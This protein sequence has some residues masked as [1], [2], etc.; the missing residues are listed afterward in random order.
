MRW[1]GQFYYF[2][3]GCLI[4]SAPFV[5][6]MMFSPMY[7][8]GIFVINQLTI[9]VCIFLELLVLFHWCICLS[10][11]PDLKDYLK[12]L[13]GWFWRV[14]KFEKTLENMYFI[15]STTMWLWGQYWET[16]TAPLRLQWTYRSLE[17]LLKCKFWYSKSELGP[18]I[19]HF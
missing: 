11:V 6:N 5:E 9:D 17:L 14:S 3:C 7:C 8:P 4:V 19:L 12:H 2:V 1:Y 18:E 15:I 16:R 13:H 10:S